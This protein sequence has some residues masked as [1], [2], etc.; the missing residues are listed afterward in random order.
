MRRHAKPIIDLT[1]ATIWHVAMADADATE[2]ARQV[3]I[4]KP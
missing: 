2:T 1:M 3:N 4:E